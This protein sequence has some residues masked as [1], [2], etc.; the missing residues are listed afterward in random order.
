[1][2]KIPQQH[3]LS[4]RACYREKSGLNKEPNAFNRSYYDYKA[5][6]IHD[7]IFSNYIKLI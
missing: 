7:A 1:M 5:L 4:R 3:N 6:R 2:L